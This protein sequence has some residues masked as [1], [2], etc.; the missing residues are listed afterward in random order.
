MGRLRGSGTMGPTR[1]VRLPAALDA[2]FGERLDRYRDRSSSEMLAGL[3]HGGLRLREGYMGIHRR[4]L[5]QHA[6]GGDA[7]YA[8]YAQ[9][10]HDTFGPDYLAHLEDWLEAEHGR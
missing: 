9:C 7:A 8:T 5:E 10:L 4:V 1:S 6:R 2:W 3:V